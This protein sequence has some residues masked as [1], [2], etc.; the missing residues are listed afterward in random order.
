MNAPFASLRR[1]RP[2]R[3]LAASAALG[4]AALA[5]MLAGSPW[6][7]PVLLAG[8]QAALLAAGIVS[9]LGDSVRP[10][11]AERVSSRHPLP[12]G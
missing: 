9:H 7:I 12:R 1:V 5:L 4:L 2:A 11:G 10:D 8:S 3:W 6:P